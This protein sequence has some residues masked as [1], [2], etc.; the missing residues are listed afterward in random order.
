VENF[1]SIKLKGAKQAF[2]SEMLLIGFLQPTNLFDL[3]AKLCYHFVTKTFYGNNFFRPKY[4][5]FATSE[6]P[7]VKFLQS[8]IYKKLIF[9]AMAQ[10][11]AFV[12]VSFSS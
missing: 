12:E 9:S 4:G 1:K 8:I 10:D 3:L 11:T 5:I 2:S 6:P 7:L